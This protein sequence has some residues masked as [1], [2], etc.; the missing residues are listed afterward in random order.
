MKKWFRKEWYKYLF[1]K[2]DNPDFCSK[3]TRLICRISHHPKGCIYY[4]SKGFEPDWRCR[5]CGD[6]L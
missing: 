4:T 2:A 1:A 3:L 6:E 5:T